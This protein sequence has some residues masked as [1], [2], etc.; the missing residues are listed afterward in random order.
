MPKEKNTAMDILNYINEMNCYPNASIAY[1]VLLTIYV[2]IVSA[3]KKLK[4]KLL[5]LYL[6]SMML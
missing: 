1:R 3:E 4:L 6:R 2:I 5:K